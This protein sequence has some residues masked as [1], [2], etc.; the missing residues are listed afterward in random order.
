MNERKLNK[1][2][3]IFIL[4]TIFVLVAAL[5]VLTVSARAIK[6]SYLGELNTRPG[7]IGKYGLVSSVNAFSSQAGVQILMKGG[8]AIDA[9]VAVNAVLQVVDP[10]MTGLDGN[11]FATIYWAPENKVYNINMTGAVPYAVDPKIHTPEDLAMGYKAGCVPGVFGGWIQAM[12]K[13]GTMSLAEVLE[14]AIDYAENGQPVSEVM[15][16]WFKNSESI[17]AIFP[18]SAR[19][20]MPNGRLPEIGEMI[21]MKDLANTFKKLV[22]AEQMALAQGKSR[23][24]ALQA[25]YDRFYKGDIAQ[26]VVQ[27]YQENDGLF[28]LKD[29]ADYEPI[30]KEPLHINYRGYDIYTTP[31]TSRSGYELTMQ[32]NLIEGFDLQEIG[33]NTSDYWHLV[34]ECIKLA[35]ADIYQYVADEAFVDIPTEAMLSKE[36]ADVRRELID[37]EKAMTYPGPGIPEELKAVAQM[38][39]SIQ[40]F[41]TAYNND[42]TEEDVEEVCFTTN[43]NVVD[44]FGNAVSSTP[45][46]GDLHGT[47]VI[48]GNTGL[49]F[50]NGTRVGS[51]APYE[52]NVNVIKGGKISLLGN[53]PTMIMK[54]GEL[55]MLYGVAGGETIG[56][57]T[58]QILLNVIDFGMGIQ[59]AIDA[60]R[61]EVTAQPNFYLP[62]ADTTLRLESRIPE[63]IAKELEEKGHKVSILPEFGGGNMAHGILIHPEHKT[64]EAGSDPRGG[65]YAIG[66]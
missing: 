59:E 27:F 61:C 47:K 56:Q 34:A 16:A 12:Q 25:A 50:N 55:F 39:T 57:V 31:S 15:Y 51:V 11:G 2:V 10:A 65:G 52:D 46:H 7:V 53:A 1:I 6:T 45:T 29:F 42:F 14:R 5:P 20:F 60:A 17:I 37:M 63:E 38:K 32:A 35:K 54:D 26:D 43:F 48:V 64:W 22:A 23:N 28:T 24:E 8:N 4:S 66:W 3:Y 62:G 36:Y 9:A 30:W 18:T 19:V 44:R 58:F 33:Y 49:L 13:F 41:T 40:S 21:Y